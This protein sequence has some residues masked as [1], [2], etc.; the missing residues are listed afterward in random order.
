MKRICT[1][2]RQ[3]SRACNGRSAA[4]RDSHLHDRVVQRHEVPEDVEVPA[5]EDQHVQLLRLQRDTLT[6]H[7]V[8]SRRKRTA[9]QKA[10]CVSRRTLAALRRVHLEKEH[11]ER[12]EVKHVTRKP[13]DVHGGSR[14]ASLPSGVSQL[15]CGNRAGTE[16][17]RLAAELLFPIFSHRR[18]M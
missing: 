16:I 11:Q 13:E 6:W 4:D 9:A 18:S 12:E 3:R 10:S 14:G 2:V 5:A 15:L 7:T 17:V 1:A 8:S